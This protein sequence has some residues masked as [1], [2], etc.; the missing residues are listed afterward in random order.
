M[1]VAHNTTLTNTIAQKWDMDVLKARYATAVIMQRVLNK[2]ALIMKQYDTVEINI[3]PNLTTGTVGATSGSFTASN[4]ACSKVNIICNIWAY[5]AEQTTDQARIQSFWTAENEFPK[6]S[7]AAFSKDYDSN[8]AGLY[9]GL[10]GLTEVGSDSSPE[11]FSPEAAATAMLRLANANIPTDNVSW[12]L[13]P[14]AYYKGW[15]SNT[16]LT[17]ANSMGVP[18]N[19]LTTGYKS[20]ILGSPMY[21]STVLSQAGSGNAYKG[22]LLHK[23]ALGIAMQLN[24]SYKLVD[25]AA[26]GTLLHTAIAQSLFGVATIRSDHGV[27]INV[28]PA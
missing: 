19:V 14:T 15:L 25:N 4:N 7:G 18:K 20:N 10:T 16:Q 2:S 26:A 27:V 11:D 8:L 22:L 5:C 28:K 9:S 6:Q 1:A 12:I 3:A 13:P 24:N 17:A 23:E 21:L